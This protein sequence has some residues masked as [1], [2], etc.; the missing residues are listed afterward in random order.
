LNIDAWRKRSEPA[1]R[2]VSAE[3]KRRASGFGDHG[4]APVAPAQAARAITHGDLE[5]EVMK[6][7]PAS[8]APSDISTGTRAN[9]NLH[10]HVW[11]DGWFHR[12]AHGALTFE[13][14]P[15]PRQQ[16]VE[17]LVLDVH[18]RDATA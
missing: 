1:L 10:L 5:I 14:A 8:P 3:G 17:R 11:L 9:L 16:E 4:G 2:I 18:A 6:D 12:A 7:I 13:R 15:T